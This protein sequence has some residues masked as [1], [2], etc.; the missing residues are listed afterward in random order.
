MWVKHIEIS[1][2]RQGARRP[3]P[4]QSICLCYC[5]GN[6]DSKCE[7]SKW[8]SSWYA[9]QY[10]TYILRPEPYS[11]YPRPGDRSKIIDFFYSLFYPSTRCLSSQASPPLPSPWET[12][13][14]ARLWA[15]AG[16]SAGAKTK[17]GSWA[18]AAGRM[19]R[20]RVRWMWRVTD[21]PPSTCVIFNMH[22]QAGCQSDA[23]LWSKYTY[24]IILGFSPL[25]EIDVY[26]IFSCI[27]EIR[28]RSHS[29]YFIFGCILTISFYLS[30]HPSIYPSIKVSSS[31][32]HLY[33]P[34]I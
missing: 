8:S 10:I 27:F 1:R 9:I 26:Q 23:C 25:H 32:I 18:S 20:R 22:T 12:T 28:P 17:T 3:T 30:I 5:H 34:S 15:G 33:Y 13:T 19:R 29:H 7:L 2:A 6:E 16:S 24:I 21:A 14:R 4:T 11:D 31:I